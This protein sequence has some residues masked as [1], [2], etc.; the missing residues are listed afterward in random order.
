MKKWLLPIMAI[1]L[2]FAV[3]C[4]NNDKT[5][6]TEIA[7]EK[8]EQKADSANMGEKM[9][10]D[11]EFMVEAAS[12][13]LMEVELGQ[14]AAQNASSAKVKEFGQRMVKDHSKANEELKSLAA[15][16]NITI[17]STPGEKHQNHI[18]DL[19]EKKGADFDKVYMRMMVE[20]HEEDVKKFEDVANNAKD[21][22]IKA[23]ASKTLPV[24]KEH[25]QMSKSI[26]DGLK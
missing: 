12:G 9:E 14:L 24:L 6:S 4:N 18:N 19:K 26:K 8:N 25:H 5:D 21:A 20:D 7:E 13:G 3:A 11:H 23:F 15:Q 10:D 17:P 1:S 16:K 2:M 22:E